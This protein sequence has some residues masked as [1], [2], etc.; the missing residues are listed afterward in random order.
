MVATGGGR[1]TVFPHQGERTDDYLRYEVTDPLSDES[2]DGTLKDPP[3]MKIVPRA[4]RGAAV[5]SAYDR[6]MG[7]AVSS[8]S[9][10]HSA[11]PWPRES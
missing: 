7:A 2:K 1:G 10:T 11:R 3:Q 6:I 8:A 5:S 4:G 9:V